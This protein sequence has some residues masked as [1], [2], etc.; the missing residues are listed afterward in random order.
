MGV[1]IAVAAL[2]AAAAFGV[3][4]V[5]SLAGL[6]RELMKLTT[7]LTGLGLA[8]G[9]IAAAPHHGEGPAKG[10]RIGSG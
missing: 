2:V 5:A 4:L 10:R 8:V 1:V 9:R 7:G 6:V 3:W